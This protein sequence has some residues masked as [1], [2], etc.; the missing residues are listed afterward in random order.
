MYVYTWSSY[1]PV[2]SPLGCP[3]LLFPLNMFSKNIPNYYKNGR[4]ERVARNNGEE[5]L[6]Y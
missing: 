1:Q 2:C 3:V 4:R 6:G 5:G